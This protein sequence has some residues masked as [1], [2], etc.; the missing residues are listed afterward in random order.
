[1]EIPKQDSLTPQSKIPLTEF[2]TKKQLQ[3]YLDHFKDL[4][5]KEVH[6]AV[7]K[8]KTSSSAFSYSF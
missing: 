3:S 1:M 8:N 6:D 7:S 5:M 4:I 2:V